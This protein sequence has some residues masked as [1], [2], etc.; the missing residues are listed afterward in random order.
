LDASKGTFLSGNGRGQFEYLPYQK[1]GLQ[2]EGEIRDMVSI[3]TNDGK[4]LIVARNDD[5][6]LA[7]RKSTK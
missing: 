7:F 6:A 2:I 3:S 4:V 1:T 5:T